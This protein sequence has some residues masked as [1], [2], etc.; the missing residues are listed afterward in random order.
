MKRTNLRAGTPPL[1]RRGFAFPRH[2]VM[3]G[4]VL[5]HAQDDT[6][7][8]EMT[9][10]QF[11]HPGLTRDDTALNEMTRSQFRRPGTPSGLTLALQSL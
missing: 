9:R 6:A 11:R 7:L 10:S 8:N 1:R 4:L 5:R 2:G 3:T